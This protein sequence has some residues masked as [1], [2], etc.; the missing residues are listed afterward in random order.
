MRDMQMYSKTLY[1]FPPIKVPMIITGTILHD[2]TW[3]QWREG[4][5]NAMTIRV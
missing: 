2:L 1:R 5:K 4:T 3:D